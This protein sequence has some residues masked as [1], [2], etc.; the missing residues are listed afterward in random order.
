MFDG[1]FV[2]MSISQPSTSMAPSGGDD[3]TT[4]TMTRWLIS[5]LSPPPNMYQYLGVI[6][7]SGYNSVGSTARDTGIEN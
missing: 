1:T 3:D 4:A 5:S 2:I 6:T 7:M